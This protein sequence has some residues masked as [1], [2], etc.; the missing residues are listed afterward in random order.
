MGTIYFTLFMII[1]FLAIPAEPRTYPGDDQKA[2]VIIYERSSPSSSFPLD[3]STI[4]SA[5]NH[6]GENN[7]ND[8]VI[9]GR[10]NVVEAPIP[11]TADQG[12]DSANADDDCISMVTTEGAPPRRKPTPPPAPKPAA[13]THPTV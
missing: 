4:I 3:L 8:V 9:N 12:C 10:E 11:K 1:G 6:D 13:P 5:I 7:I 2:L